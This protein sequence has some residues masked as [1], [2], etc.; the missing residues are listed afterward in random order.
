MKGFTWVWAGTREAALLDGQ[1]REVG[2]V[3]NEDRGGWNPS[4]MGW[5]RREVV[6]QYR[7]TA[8]AAQRVVERGV[9]Q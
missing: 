5:A 8:R 7:K 6:T 3:L 9:R 1:G 2:A 4:W